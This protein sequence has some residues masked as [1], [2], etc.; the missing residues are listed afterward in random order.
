MKKQIPKR[1]RKNCLYKS[2]GKLRY[3]Q[4]N[5]LWIKRWMLY[6]CCYCRDDWMY[7]Y[8][9]MF[10]WMTEWITDWLAIWEQ[11]HHCYLYWWLLFLCQ[12]KEKMS[13]FFLR[14]MHIEISSK[15]EFNHF[16][17]LFFLNSKFNF[18][19]YSSLKSYF[20]FIK[21]SILQF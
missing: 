16:K 1:T 12:G 21:E 13:L 20:V 11:L 7:G 5:Y 18:M 4:K 17:S 10:A 3:I 14:F 19:L 6:S 15:K 9:L 8:G 2:K